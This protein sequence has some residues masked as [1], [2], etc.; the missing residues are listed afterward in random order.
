MIIGKY[1][2]QLLN[3]SKRVV[4]PGFG[5]LEVKE[6]KGEVSKAGGLINPPGLTVKFDSGYSKDDGLLAAPMVSGKGMEKE[7]ADQRVLELIDAIKFSLDKGEAYLLHETGTFLKD[8]DGKVHFQV[9]PD[10]VLEP[11]HY[12]LESLDLL[13]LDE[14]PPEED[15][16]ATEPTQSVPP[17]AQMRSPAPPTRHDEG[18]LRQRRRWRALYITAGT[19]ILVLVALI[20]IPKKQTPV[21]ILQQQ[22]QLKQAEK[23]RAAET[24]IQAAPVEPE[25]VA[26]ESEEPQ[27]SANFY[28]IAGSFKNLA[29]ASEMQDHLKAQGYQSEVL[30]TENRMYRVSVSSFAT[31]AEAEKVLSRVKSD[32]GL[33]SAWILSN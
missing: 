22:E 30:I 27:L 5:N 12:G 7:E 4:F 20:L 17:R 26:D 19:L 1:I 28:I 16:R 24:P 32:T 15:K 10:W 25:P 6:V 21:E 14:L 29:N 13:E 11:D 33:S 3:D 31:E 9:V 2:R 8:D 23:E 18:S